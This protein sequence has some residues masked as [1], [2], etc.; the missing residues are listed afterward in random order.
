MGDPFKKVQP[1]DRLEIPAAAY[2][3]FI[4]AAL[5]HRASAQQ[6]PPSLRTRR[7]VLVRNDTG[8]A[9][10]RY[11]VVGIGAPLIDPAD[12]ESGFQERIAFSGA[13]PA[14]EH[15]A[16]FG[17]LQVPLPAGAIGSAVVAGATICRLTIVDA[18]HRFAEL[19]A[20]VTSELRT[21]H[22]GSAEILWKESGTGSGKWAVVRLNSGQLVARFELLANLVP[23]GSA[24]AEL[25]DDPTVQFTVYDTLGMRRGRGKGTLAGSAGYA[26][27]YHD[28]GHWEIIQMQ[29]M[30]LVLGALVNETNGVPRGDGTGTFAVDNVEILQPIGGL[31]DSPPTVARNPLKL[32]LFDNDPVLLFWN[33]TDLVWDAVGRDRGGTLRHA[34]VQTGFTN[35]SADVRRTV[36]VRECDKDGNNEAGDPFD[37]FTQIREGKYTYLFEGDVVDY[38]ESETG[39][40]IIVSPHHDQPFGWIEWCA[41]DPSNVKP[42]WALCDGSN[43][44]VDLRDRF[45]V[46]W[47][48]GGKSAKDRNGDAG[49]YANI[50]DTGGYAWH[51]ASTEG[52]A[53][54][55]PDHTFDVSTQPADQN[56][57][58]ATV[59]VVDEIF[60]DPQNQQSIRAFVHKGTVSGDDTDNRPPYY[61]LAA[62]Q[63]VS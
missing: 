49:D 53:N 30:A 59:N 33:E 54:N 1:G 48:P 28:T 45:V 7:T 24:L 58:G 47:R 16:R 10:P 55:H 18:S 34:K 15:F 22:A 51:G 9:L 60:E 52:A 38:V 57:D 17:I 6:G 12:N 8:S 61:V 29:P 39:D 46:G 36:S 13:T 63:R 35:Q 56:L 31:L 4:D 25:P 43:G 40:R 21:C 50:G 5:A 32:R 62:I 37:V 26:R 11:A 41:V 42:G 20:G 3:A 27:Y 23:G 44:T 2:N 14:A 19:S